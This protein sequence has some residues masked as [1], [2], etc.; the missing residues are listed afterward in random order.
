LTF[1][2]QDYLP[3]QLEQRVLLSYTLYRK[4]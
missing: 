2:L 1:F 3:V 4:N